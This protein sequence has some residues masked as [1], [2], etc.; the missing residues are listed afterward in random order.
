MSSLKEIAVRCAFCGKEQT[1]TVVVGTDELGY[2]DL[3]TRPPG[4]K[5]G[6]L[7]YNIQLCDKCGYANKRIS[8]YIPK[9]KKDA[10]LGDEYRAVLTDDRLDRTAKAFLLSAILHA[11]AEDTKAAGICFLSAAWIFDDL[12]QEEKAVSAR[13]KA[14]RAFTPYVELS[15][16]VLVAAVI[17]DMQR[18]V[19]SFTEAAEAARQLLEFGV[20]ETVSRVLNFQKK[21]CGLRDNK[22][23][24]ISE[25]T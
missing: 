6:T 18:R 9:L 7:R 15:G 22:C 23:H 16:D 2:M 19:G 21:L 24:D 8:E 10:L 1:V 4:R 3:D 17:V 20:D 12:G 14:V 5:R 25:A 13:K 11:S